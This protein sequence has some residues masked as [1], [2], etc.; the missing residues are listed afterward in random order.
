[1]TDEQYAS[2]IIKDKAWYEENI[3]NKVG[4]HDIS[5]HI[6]TRKTK[7][8]LGIKSAG[9]LKVFV[10]MKTTDGDEDF[11]ERA[12][13]QIVYKYDVCALPSHPLAR[14]VPMWEDAPP[15]ATMW[16]ARCP[17][18]TAWVITPQSKMATNEYEELWD[19]HQ[20][21]MEELFGKDKV[22]PSPEGADGFMWIYTKKDE[23]KYSDEYIDKVSGR[24]KLWAERLNE[25]IIAI[26]HM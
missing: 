6:D 10:Q 3:K 5:R 25:N 20:K 24:F 7:K 9:K 16:A 21:Y 4:F 12:N 23:T 15:G 1:M 19:Q 26:G 14:D 2:T 11:D 8:A 18:G 22:K 17:Q 13:P